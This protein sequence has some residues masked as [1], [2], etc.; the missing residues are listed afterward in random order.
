M[1]LLAVTALLARQWGKTTEGFADATPAAPKAGTDAKKTDAPKADAPAPAKKAGLSVAWIV[2]IVIFGAFGFYAAYLSWSCNTLTNM[3]I[4]AK[5]FFAVFAF[6]GGFSY[7]VS[8]LF[9]RWSDC[10]YIR[11]NMAPAPASPSPVVSPYQTPAANRGGR[12]RRGA[13]RGRR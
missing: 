12:G 4:P 8:Y 1:D 7:L 11:E 9:F 5:I 13:R 6:L 3:S 2:F 10:K